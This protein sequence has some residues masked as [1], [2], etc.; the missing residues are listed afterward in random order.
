MLHHDA[1]TTSY[2]EDARRAGNETGSSRP[3]ELAVQHEIARDVPPVVFDPRG[4]C[5]VELLLIEFG[6]C[7]HAH[8][9]PLSP[10]KGHASR[11]A[12]QNRPCSIGPRAHRII[13]LSSDARSWRCQHMPPQRSKAC[14][15]P[16]GPGHAS[17][18]AIPRLLAFGELRAA[19]IWK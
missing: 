19:R 13:M 3:R 15:V 16:G 17:C 5:V 1:P 14:S 4:I 9:V 10:D 8:S 12:L 2:F 18:A 7:R 6:S 11:H